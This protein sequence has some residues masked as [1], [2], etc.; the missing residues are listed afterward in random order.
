VRLIHHPNW[1]CSVIISLRS[2]LPPQPQGRG[3]TF[4]RPDLL[5]FSAMRGVLLPW[6]SPLQRCVSLACIP[7]LSN[8]LRS[9][10]ISLRSSLPPQPQG[11]RATFR[12]RRPDLLVFSAYLRVFLRVSAVRGVLLPWSSPLERCVSLACLPP[13]TLSNWLRS[14]IISLRSPLPPQPQGR[15]ATFRL[16]RPDPLVFSAYLRVFLR[17]SAVRG[18]PLLSRESRQSVKAFSIP[19]THAE[20]APYPASPENLP[21]L[22][23]PFT[24]IRKNLPLIPNDLRLTPDNFPKSPCYNSR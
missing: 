2:P 5:V 20:S 16:G 3:A 15:R 18:V 21:P 22:P 19:P 12:L 9:V 23:T 1:H 24:A 7:T 17:V 13:P 6:S 4:R 8:W 10:I 14:V 11:R